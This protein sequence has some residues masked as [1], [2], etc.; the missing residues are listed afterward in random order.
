MREADGGGDSKKVRRKFRSRIV[1]HMRLLYV[2]AI[3]CEIG[4]W[5]EWRCG[6]ENKWTVGSVKEMFTL[7]ADMDAW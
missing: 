4:R 6:V 1:M 3:V 2:L 7:R 5:V